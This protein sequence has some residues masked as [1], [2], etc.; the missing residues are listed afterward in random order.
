M[1]SY[2]SA[3]QKKPQQHLY[4]LIREDADSLY[5]VLVYGGAI[6]LLS[7]VIPITVQTLVNTVAFGSLIQPLVVLT[8]VVLVTLSGVAVLKALQA[9]VVER[10]QRRILVRYAFKATEALSRAKLPSLYGEHGPEIV[11]RFMDAMTVQKGAAQLLI[12][13]VGVFL[14]S[15]FGLILLAFYH[16][17]LLAFDVLLIVM[18]LF[19]VFYLGKGAAISSV[20][21]SKSKYAIVAWLEELIRHPQ[22]ARSAQGRLSAL[23]KMDDLCSVYLKKRDHHYSILFKQILGTLGLQA[24]V[25]ALLLGLGGYLVILNQL[26]L[27]Q[28]VAAEIVV[29]AVLAGVS[30]FWKELETVYDLVAAAEKLSHVVQIPAEQHR[31]SS[32]VADSGLQ[33]SAVLECHI[34]SFTDL[35]F[36]Y[37]SPIRLTVRNNECVLVHGPRGSGKTLLAQALYGLI[38]IGADSS[39][40]WRGLAYKDLSSDF[41]RTKIRL[42]SGNSIFSGSIVE[43]LTFG[44]SSAPSLELLHNALDSVGLANKIKSFKDGLNTSLCTFGSPLSRSESTL[45]AITREVLSSPDLIIID[46]EFAALDP[47]DRQRVLDFILSK[48]ISLIVMSNSNISNQHSFNRVEAL[49]KEGT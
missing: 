46:D 4:E 27:G 6:G 9:Y 30:K 5:L 8:L 1:G 7:L 45:L 19:V 25:N 10:T 32:L 12:S 24:F 34:Q 22:L 16:P 31:H 40:E 47:D 33:N 49:S 26:T 20:Q 38:G 41:W 44:Q 28:L 2:D 39:L 18:I 37:N 42:V 36:Q 15:V 13:G 43:N 11:N 35:D 21:E 23:D 29:N 14:Q 17:L 48:G 3:A